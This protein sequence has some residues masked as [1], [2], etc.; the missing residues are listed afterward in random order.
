MDLMR[1]HDS[2]PQAICLHPEPEEGDEAS[3][4][5]FSMVADVGAKRMW[6][7]AGNPC[8][9]EYVRDRPGRSGSAT[10]THRHGEATY[11]NYPP[12][13]DACYT[14]QPATED[15]SDLG[16]CCR[17]EGRTPDGTTG[18]GHTLVG[19]GRTRERGN[20]MF[21]VK[22]T[23]RTKRLTVTVLSASVIA[24]T[25]FMNNAFAQDS[26]SASAAAD[27]VVFTMGGVSEPSGL[28]PMVGYLG[29]DYTFWALAYDL[30]INWSTKDFSP[31]FQHSIVTSVDTSDDL[32]TFTYHFRPGMLWSD[33]EPFTAADA[34]WTLNYYKANNTPNYSADLELM[35]SAK[36][37]DDTTMVVTSTAPTSFYSGDSVF[38]YEYLLPEHIWGKFEDDYKGAKQ[39]PGFPSIGT[40]PYIITNYV[41]NQFVQLDRN[42]NYWGND[43]GMTPHIDQIIY[44]IYGNQDAEAAALQSGE[45]DYGD[46]SSANI[47]NT[48]KSRGL[49]TRG[50]VIPVSARSG[51]TPARRTKPTRPVDSRRTATATRRSRTSSSDRPCDA[52]W[53]TKPSSTK[54]SSATGR[55]ASPRSSRTPRPDA[56]TA[57][58]RRSG[59]LV[60]HR[61][62]QPDA[63]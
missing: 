37:T 10:L 63:R 53:T 38:M 52:R 19:E 14:D 40:G 49:E 9:S 13:G 22:R 5:M 31:D 11:L 3:A 47:L 6:V 26:P 54:S 20:A 30:P 7:T 4:V 48:L 57:G 2:A 1:D 56:W 28:N 27:K 60:Q 32:M 16:E 25:L 39:E 44:R 21:R 24:S 43:N 61:G 29:L 36:A 17:M 62:R 35:D 58:S 55:R 8:E 45:I 59:S 18:R 42:P 51:S 34:A 50:A 33:G 12:T 46:F 41:K 15:A 23:R